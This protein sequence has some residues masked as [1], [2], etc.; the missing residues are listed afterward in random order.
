MKNNKIS[1]YQKAFNMKEYNV[2]FY[3][4]EYMPYGSFMFSVYN[5][6]ARA[7]MFREAIVHK[8]TLLKIYLN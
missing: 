3:P 2:F 8:E 1:I 5:E 6:L 4:F 7:Q